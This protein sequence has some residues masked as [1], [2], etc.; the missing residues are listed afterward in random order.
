MSSLRR[1]LVAC[2]VELTALV[3]SQ[4]VDL[5]KAWYTLRVGSKSV[6]P[7]IHV[8]PVAGQTP[9]GFGKRRLIQGEGPSGVCRVSRLSND[10][11]QAPNYIPGISCLGT[12]RDK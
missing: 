2:A 12:G 7:P 3:P 8:E 11:P 9:P 5:G 4:V 6:E 1:T 10:H